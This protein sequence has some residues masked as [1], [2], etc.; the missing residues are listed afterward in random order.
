MNVLSLFD[1]VG[2]SQL[3][4]SS[5]I[6]GNYTMY[7]SETNND[8]RT[9][10]GRHFPNTIFL[11]KVQAVNTQIL[12]KIDLLLGGSPCQGFSV[13]GKQLAF[14]DPRSALF[15]EFIRIKNSL[16]KNTPFL[17]E[18]VP[19]KKE[20]R[21]IISRYIGV[22]PIMIDS[23][24]FSPQQRKRFY[25]TN[26]P[27]TPITSKNTQT[28]ENIL[29]D[30]VDKKYYI[31]PNR[32]VIILDNEVKR[33]KIAFIGKDSQGNRIYSIHNK[34]VTLCA[35]AGG[36]GAKTGIYA[37]PC[38]TPDRLYKRQNGRRFKPPDSKFYCLTAQDR[39]GVLIDHHIRKLT[40]IECERLQNIPDNY[41]QG[42]SDNKRYQMIGN[43]WTVN[44]IIHLL[45]PLFK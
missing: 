39:H 30:R 12:P 1:G 5:H 18:N 34:S 6:W 11:A 23:K 40:P 21:D 2:C 44:V 8:C 16:P 31:D 43:A 4:L 37:L 10:V 20:F 17:L 38:L 28:V 29:L 19:M 41:T 42:F 35:F 7:S 13:A 14:K 22:E 27:Y 33:K 26:I 9:V 45:K 36:L 15:F 24:D 32:A 3:A 25:W